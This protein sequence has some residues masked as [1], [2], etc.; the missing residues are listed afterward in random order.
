MSDNS[1]WSLLKALRNGAVFGLAY[2]LVNLFWAR[3]T[4]SGL[5][6]AESIGG[7]LGAVFAAALLFL[8]VAFLRNLIVKQPE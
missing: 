1:K 8:L 5:P 7:L 2:G 4:L 6:I 3:F